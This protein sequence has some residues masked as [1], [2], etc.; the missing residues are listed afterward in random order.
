MPALHLLWEEQKLTKLHIPVL[1]VI[2]FWEQLSPSIKPQPIP[3]SPPSL[4]FI[5]TR[6][7]LHVNLNGF[8]DKNVLTIG[9]LR[10]LLWETIYYFAGASGGSPLFGAKGEQ[11]ESTV[12]MKMDRTT[13]NQT[14]PHA[15]GYWFFPFLLHWAYHKRLH[16]QLQLWYSDSLPELMKCLS[17][18][19]FAFCF[20]VTRIKCI[21]CTHHF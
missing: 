19:V 9:E 5:L 21:V 7:V 13:K 17:N 15:S 14:L 11:M 20:Q 4:H 1:R 8:I 16:Q 12:F 3:F 6:D 2:N 18:S 10:Y